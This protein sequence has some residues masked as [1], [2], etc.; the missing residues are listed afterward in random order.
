MAFWGI[1]FETI[2]LKQTENFK[3][4]TIIIYQL[5]QYYSHSWG[6]VSFSMSEV[7]FTKTRSQV[8]KLNKGTSVDPCG[9]PWEIFNS[10]L[11]EEPT[12]IF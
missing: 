1:C 2:I 12:L 4:I 6:I 11:N 3:L 5:S 8:T 7:M 9:T 10:L